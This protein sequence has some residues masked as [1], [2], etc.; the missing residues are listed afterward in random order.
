M[1][2]SLPLVWFLFFDSV[3]GQQCE[4]KIADFVSLPPSALVGQFRDAVQQKYDKPNYL[5]D[6]PAGALIV[7]ENQLAFDEK[8][9][10]LQPTKSLGSLGSQDDKLIVVVPSSGLRSQTQPSSFPLCQVPFYSNIHNAT[11]RDGWIS[12]G[13][14]IPSTFIENLYI[15]E[16]FRVIASSINPGINKAIITGTPGIGKS[17]FLIYLLWKLVKEGKRVLFIY[18]P[19]NI[20]YDGNGGVFSL[21]KVPSSIDFSFWNDTLWCLFDAKGKNETHLSE[22]PYELC[23][24]IVSTSPRREMVNDFKKPPV[25]QEF[26]MPTWSEAELENIAPLFPNAT[27]WR[28]RFENLGGIPRHVL[29]VTTRPPTEMLEAA[30]SDCSLDDLTLR[31][32]KQL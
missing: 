31:Q 6:I 25:P 19:F 23:R 14:N 32:V 30:C 28:V 22:F 3:T 27:E 21:D 4:G 9:E 29:E 26:Y 24:F 5:K 7:Y 2:S 18:H 17:L 13:Q 1:S 10:P 16:S 15:R 8:K 11:E 20:Y 12:F